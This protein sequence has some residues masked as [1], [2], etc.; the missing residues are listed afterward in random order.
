MLVFSEPRHRHQL[1]SV[2]LAGNHMFYVA[3]GPRVIRAVVI[4]TKSHAQ[5]HLGQAFFSMSVGLDAQGV[6]LHVR[7]HDMCTWRQYDREGHS[8]SE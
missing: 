7:L 2:V 1:V 8:L 6:A 4:A 5:D 3:A